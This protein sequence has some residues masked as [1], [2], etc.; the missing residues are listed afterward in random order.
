M[1]VLMILSFLLLLFIILFSRAIYCTLGARKLSP[2]PPPASQSCQDKY[3]NR[4]SQM[5]KCAT[6]SSKDNYD[7]TE[8][9]KLRTTVETL[10]PN[11]HRLSDRQIFGNDCWVYRI[12]GQD[13]SRRV[14][15]M[16]HHDV[17]PVEGDWKY[18]PFSGTISDGRI[19]GRGT[20]DTKT[21]LFSELQAIDELLEEGW[22]PPIDVFLGSS[23]NEEVAGD[24]IPLVVKYFESRG[25]YFD[26]VL[27]E[28]G[29]VISSPMPG[30]SCK[31]AML[32][33][34]EKGRCTLKCIAS[35]EPNHSGLSGNKKT[36]VVRLAEFITAVVKRPPFVTRL[37]PQVRCMFDHLSA[38]MSLPMRLVFANL[39]LF[40][41]LITKVMPALNPQAG[42]MVGTQCSF[43][44]IECN[45]SK[46]CSCEA[47]LRCVDENDLMNDI[48]RLKEMAASFGVKVTSGD[49]NEFFRPSETNNS[50]FVNVKKCVNKVFPHAACA[51]FVLPANTDARHFTKICNCVVRFAPIEID[52]Q[53]FASVH[54]P[55]E[56]INID[57]IP[58]AVQ[59]YREFLKGLK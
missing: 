7:D 46:E 14:M 58:S 32:A 5:I 54:S 52:K 28:G 21:S 57:A 51:P 56:N 6:I 43:P 26:L 3:S 31:C 45:G 20:V 53:Q 16:S 42:A 11:L 27:D 12:K 38:Y 4:L 10:F 30:V 23:H 22:Q 29:A 33:I 1:I 48:R 50:L 13:S 19:W 17:A 47:F 44:S 36:C 59:F 24:G 2:K 25:E 15:L 49:V 40:E 9:S 34:H 37:Y 18:P 55:N 35:D 39:W 41:P 8:F